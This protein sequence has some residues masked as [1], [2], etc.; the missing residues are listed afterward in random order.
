MGD[1]TYIKYSSAEGLLSNDVIDIAISAEGDRYL[2]HETKGLTVMSREEVFDTLLAY[3]IGAFG[4]T[5]TCVLIPE[6]KPIIGS[7]DGFSFDGIPFYV[8]GLSNNRVNR[9]R[10]F[11]DTLWFCTQR[12]IGKVGVAEISEGPWIS[13]DT[14]DGLPSNSVN[15]LVVTS[16]GT[17]AATNSG[18][19]RLDGS[20]WVPETLGL[21]SLKARAITALDT[22]IWVGT[23]NGIAYWRSGAWFADDE[24]L[25]SKDI[26]SLSFDSSGVLW[27][28][29]W[30]EGAAYRTSEWT[31]WLSPGPASNF[32]NEVFT[33]KDG[34]IWC[35]HFEHFNPETD[36][37]A[38][39]RLEGDQWTVFEQ[40]NFG[41]LT[42]FVS[43]ATD[44]EGN[45]WF[46]TFG[47]GV[48]EYTSSD[49]FVI[50]DP[51][52]SGLPSRNTSA[53][54]VDR[55]NNR[56]FSFY[57]TGGV[58]EGVA[59]LLSDDFTWLTF[60]MGARTEGICELAQDQLGVLW[61]A[62]CDVGYVSSVDFMGTLTNLTDDQWREYGPEE[63]NSGGEIH[64]LGVDAENRVWVGTANGIRIIAF[65]QICSTYYDQS[66]SE[67]RSDF[68]YDIEFDSRGGVWIGTDRGLNH[69]WASGLWD[70]SRYL[71][72][73]EEV[74]SV[75]FEPGEEVVWVGTIRGLYRI[76][77]DWSREKPEEQLEM[78]M[79]YPNPLDPTYERRMVAFRYAPPGA[80]IRIYTLS[81]R[82][83]DEL[84]A[85]T[86][87]ATDRFGAKVSSGIY[88]YQITYRGAS[89][90]GKFAIIN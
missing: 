38:L 63:L 46:T 14:S 48:L 11:M 50:Y 53:I 74:K 60:R 8:G 78:V 90:A 45:R 7:S 88:I 30:G 1:P 82:F 15:D 47:H 5:L 73:D 77:P 36:Q 76:L 3:E 25:L 69:I 9:I 26:R 54:L 40:S 19:A 68:I 2:L 34:E 84:T 87:D 67:L 52:N 71:I 72:P 31:H 4:D 65:G 39:S 42:N 61:L 57:V 51:G 81:G 13:Y 66:N 20:S 86:W 41:D 16:Y 33:G 17:W 21:P 37:S 89:K 18:V 35:T 55:A 79:V 24:G 59:C 44:W 85:P 80:R 43:G 12:G 22:L 62:S 64:A 70:K 32:I 6:D 56:F 23:E 58:N 10:L 75:L 83:V 28:G 27:A 49:S 29:T